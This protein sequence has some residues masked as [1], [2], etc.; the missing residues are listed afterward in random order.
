MRILQ[1][2][3]H[4]GVGGTETFAI[5]LVRGLHDRGHNVT[6]VNTWT[7]S[8]LNAAAQAAGIPFA[9]LRGGGRRI[10]PRWFW[11]VSR[12][13]RRHEFDIV[14]TYGLRVS[15][16]LRLM[17][18]RLGLRH[19]VMGVRGLDQ[20]RTGVQAI[21]DRRTEHLLDLVVCNAEAVA[22]KRM[23]VVGTPRSRIRVIPNGVDLATF[24]PGSE[25]P[26]RAS[27]N[28]PDGFLFAM[29]ASFRVEKDHETLLEAIRI[30]GDRLSSA[31][32]VL[33][34]GGERRDDIADRARRMGLADRVLFVG[35]VADVR[36]YLRACDAFV[37][38][39]S[40]EGMPRAMMEAMAMGKAVVSTDVGGV[41]E[42]AV[43]EEHALLVPPRSPEALADA[44]LRVM[45]APA[46]G[47]RLGA[48]AAL[49][50]R[51][52]FSHKLMIDRHVDLYES[53]LRGGAGGWA[54]EREAR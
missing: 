4:C 53:L 45:Q 2:M 6:L 20:Q 15:L 40:S 3:G 31:R 18:R 17:Q 39:S 47:Q 9:G 8:P 34:G 7:D 23:S 38:S 41:P 46:L 27:L 16:G 32:F 35:T 48:A 37:L 29:V 25:S 52:D 11:V 5:S 19:H 28:L 51:S 13:L 50:I 21:W 24:G 43:H 49:R 12:F 1:L 36:P 33:I 10:G 54:M 14:H 42:V 44:L 26:S 30:G 22:E